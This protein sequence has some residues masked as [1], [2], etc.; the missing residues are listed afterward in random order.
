MDPVKLVL[1]ALCAVLTFLI[2]A[3]SAAAAP[4]MFS[5]PGCISATTAQ[6]PQIFVLAGCMQNGLWLTD[7]TWSSWGSDGAD[8]T[9]TLN[10]NTCEYGCADRRSHVTA[11]VV[12]HATRPAPTS[13]KGCPAGVQVYGDVTLAFPHGVPADVTAKST[14]EGMPA[15]V[16]NTPA[17]D[18][19]Q[20]GYVMCS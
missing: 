11:P 18:A 9:G 16:R 19:R 10:V 8:G 12:V 6:R 7:M 2:G 4:A 15:T 17:T 1:S 14:Y 5:L 13:V 3:P 20:W